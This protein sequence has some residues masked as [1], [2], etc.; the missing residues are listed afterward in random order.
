M[1][2]QRS[3]GAAARLRAGGTRRGSPARFPLRTASGNRSRQRCARTRVAYGGRRA[4]VVKKKSEN[5][6][7][8]ES[9]GA[10]CL[11]AAAWRRLPGL[12]AR[13]S[14]RPP[15]AAPRPRAGSGQEHAAGQR[16]QDAGRAHATFHHLGG[17]SLSNKS[18]AITEMLYHPLGPTRSS[19]WSIPELCITSRCQV[20][21]RQRRIPACG[22]KL[23]RAL[24]IA[25]QSIIDCLEMFSAPDQGGSTS[26]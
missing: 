11:K 9:R 5:L 17:D 7:A 3:A 2:T 13:G 24:K 19:L 14:L 15:S 22:S 4:A 10:S 16:R 21:I 23:G 25:A 1:G 12:P 18:R 26:P 6:A 20:F 8:R